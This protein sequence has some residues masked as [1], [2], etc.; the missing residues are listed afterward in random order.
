MGIDIRDGL[1]LECIQCALCVDACN[2]IMHK[3]GRP[4]NLIAYDTIANQEASAKGTT[5]KVKLLRPRILLYFGLIAVVGLIMLAA[6]LNRAVLEANVIADRNPLFVRFANG[7]IR[8]G[9]TVKILNKLHEPRTIRSGDFRTSG[10]QADGRR[11]GRRAK[12]AVV[13]PTDVLAEHRVFI[14]VP[15]AEAAKLGSQTEPFTFI[16]HDTAS[17]VP[18]QARRNVPEALSSMFR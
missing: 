5:A 9:F 17:D 6:L 13:V 14:S 1:Q 18:C 12:P 11:P 4:Q 15:G 8:N 16:V 7:D 10:C 3:I 2:D